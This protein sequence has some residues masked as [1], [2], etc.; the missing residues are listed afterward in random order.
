MDFMQSKQ[1]KAISHSCVV[2]IIYIYMGKH[3]S[4]IVTQVKQSITANFSYMFM[5]CH[6]R[7]YMALIS[8][9]NTNVSF[10]KLLFSTFFTDNVHL[11]HKN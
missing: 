1:R 2:L 10:C 5:N 3:V 11:Y 8:Y 7:G 6:K 9:F 4:G